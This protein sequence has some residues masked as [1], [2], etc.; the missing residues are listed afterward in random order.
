M[1]IRDSLIT[2]YLT[3]IGIEI[4]MV[5]N[6]V[7]AVSIAMMGGIDLILMD[8]HMPEMEG[9]EAVKRLR[10]KGFDKP[11]LAFTASDDSKDI[12]K[13][14]DAGCNGVLE[15]PIKI[16]GLHEGL[17]K[18]LGISSTTQSPLV[19]LDS[20]IAPIA[21]HF[22]ENISDLI[23]TMKK[24][25]TSNDYVVLIDKAHQVKGIAGALGFPKLTESAKRLES[26]IN[27][28]KKKTIKNHFNAFTKEIQKAKQQFE[29]SKQ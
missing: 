8:Q 24:A 16:E 10:S 13:M 11:I 20:E 15:K 29:S 7:Q 5:E 14:I 19:H 23:S 4:V 17:N 28:E 9:P 22:I 2:R 6:G 25:L 1:C 3:K 21:E 12:S 27:S 18:Y 26:A